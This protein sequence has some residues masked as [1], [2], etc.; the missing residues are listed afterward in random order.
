MANNMSILLNKIEMKLGTKGI[1]L[2]DDICKET[3]AKPNEGP[4]AIVTIPDFSALYP[5]KISVSL[6]NAPKKGRYYLLDE[7]VGLSEDVKILGVRD[8]NWE[9]YQNSGASTLNNGYGMYSMYQDN[10]GVEDLIMQAGMTHLGSAFSTANTIFVE[11]K[12]PNMIMLKSVT[13]VEISRY[14]INYPIEIFIEH[15]L[16]LSTIPV[17]QMKAFTDLATCDVASYLY[18]YLKYYDELPT[19][20]ANVDLKM[21]TLRSYADNREAIYQKLDEDHV[22]AANSNQPLI[23]TI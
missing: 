12:E 6:D 23:L 13:G 7:A 18:E 5:T 14:N 21:E 8:I 11:F 9:A 22:S 3:W 15:P 16:N 19:L 2:P 20:F 17:T 1:N 4:I 10:F